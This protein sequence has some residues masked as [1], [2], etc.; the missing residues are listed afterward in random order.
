MINKIQFETNEYLNPNGTARRV[1]QIAIH[2]CDMWFRRDLTC[3]RDENLARRLADDIGIEVFDY[4]DGSNAPAPLT[5]EEQEGF[6]ES[7]RVFADMP[8]SARRLMK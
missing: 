4:R 7:F 8:V 1:D 3:E 2:V 6:S 5:D